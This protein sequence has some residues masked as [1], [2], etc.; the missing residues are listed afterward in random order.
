MNADALTS[1]LGIRY[2][3][4][5]GRR[6]FSVDDEGRTVAGVGMI[7]NI[8]GVIHAVPRPMLSACEEAI[9]RDAAEDAFF[10]APREGDVW[11]HSV[12]DGIPRW[13]SHV[14]ALYPKGEC[15]LFADEFGSVTND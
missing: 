12:V 3:E 14:F 4:P 10:N 1:A 6:H 11:H 9:L 5:F 8:D 2:E 15:A 7:V 13:T